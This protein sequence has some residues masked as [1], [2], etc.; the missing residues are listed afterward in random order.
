[1]MN[2]YSHSFP[3][4]ELSDI[5]KRRCNIQHLFLWKVFVNLKH[6]FFTKAFAVLPGACPP[7]L[8][9][10][11]SIASICF[12]YPSLPALSPFLAQP[13]QPKSLECAR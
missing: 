2:Q 11:I 12:P 13:N 9:N 3:L 10:L 6:Y 8:T 5:K 4:H 7:F 1:M